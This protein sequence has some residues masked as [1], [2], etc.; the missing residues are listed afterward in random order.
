MDIL[1]KTSTES[2][3]QKHLCAL[4]VINCSVLKELRHDILSH[5]IDGL[6][7]GS[8]IGKPKNN[9][10]LRKKQAGCF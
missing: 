7:Q 4:D 6:N 8:G 5:F 9:S 3:L 1:Q 2:E 10:L